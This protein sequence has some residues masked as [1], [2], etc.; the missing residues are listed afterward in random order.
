MSRRGLLVPT[1]CLV[2]IA[3]V[4]VMLRDAEPAVEVADEG[5]LPQG[6]IVAPDPSSLDGRSE[7]RSEVRLEL[8]SFTRLIKGLEIPLGN[9][10]V[11]ITTLALAQLDAKRIEMRECVATFDGKYIV[12]QNVIRNYSIKIPVTH[13]KLNL[14]HTTLRPQVDREWVL[15][16]DPDVDA[17]VDELRVDSLIVP[18]AAARIV[19]NRLFRRTIEDQIAGEMS[20]PLRS[21]VEPMWER[22]NRDID[23]AIWN[24]PVAGAVSLRPIGASLSQVA[25]DD[26]SQ[27][28][29]VGVG[30]DFS[31]VLVVGDAP[32]EVRL[33]SVSLPDLEELPSG[34]PETRLRLPVVVPVCDLSRYW[35]PLSATLAGGDF[36]INSVDFSERDGLMHGRMHFAYKRESGSELLVPRDVKGVVQF[37]FRPTCDAGRLGISDFAFTQKSNSLL[38]DLAGATA[39]ASIREVFEEA[40]PRISGDLF[41]QAEMAAR[42]RVNDVLAEAIEKWASANDRLKHELGKAKPDV[43]GIVFLPR[44]VVV[45]DGHVIVTLEADANVSVTLGGDAK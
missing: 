37:Q 35:S 39:N 4:G 3:A 45:K 18:D 30:L 32:Q 19:V 23:L 40:V 9:G 27:A 20:I 17:H 6:A 1:V 22:A 25:V 10:K 14:A 43:S 36:S 16:A 33:A 12:E 34:R 24:A 29:R 7:L 26:V 21:L 28:I 15:Q 44:S 31:S 13:V 38:V 42:G 41:R 8:G 2:A 5:P 11:R